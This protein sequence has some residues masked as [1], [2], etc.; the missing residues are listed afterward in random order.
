MNWKMEQFAIRGGERETFPVKLIGD[1]AAAR[2]LT[3]I[4]DVSAMGVAGPTRGSWHWSDD[5]TARLDGVDEIGAFAL[6]IHLTTDAGRSA[7]DRFRR[8]T[9]RLPVARPA[10]H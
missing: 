1:A 10:I 6:E 3:L 7:F 5:A 8:I 2:L 9:P 4:N